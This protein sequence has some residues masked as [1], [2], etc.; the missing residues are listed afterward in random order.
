MARIG[1]R[2]A[3]LVAACG[4]G[5]SAVRAAD[6]PVKAPPSPAPYTAARNWSGLYVG[7]HVGWGWADESATFLSTSGLA[8]DPPG[9]SYDAAHDGFLGGLQLGYDVQVQNWVF[10]IGA[11]VSWTTAS[12]DRVTIGALVADTVIHTQ[13]ETD[14]YATLTG[15]I[16]Y[17]WSNVL[18]YGKGGVAWKRSVY[19]GF[20]TFGGATVAY[21]DLE[22]TRTGWTVGGGVE[23][24][25]A[26]HWSVFGEY[27]HMDFGTR[28]YNFFSPQSLTSNY[29]V[30]TTVDQ[31]KLGAN[32]RF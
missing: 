15:R 3:V 16:G 4:L 7:G 17:A 21:D 25:F 14:S 18:V 5:S 1:C 31:A 22:T 2:L 20:A 6:L 32:Y 30:D 29:D 11:D 9:T 10:G 27:N 13:A 26:P 8:F 23:W 19:G 12:I 28:N 24:A